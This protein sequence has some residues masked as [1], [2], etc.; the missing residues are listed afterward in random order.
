MSTFIQDIW[1][2]FLTLKS[3]S[4]NYYLN[5]G[6]DNSVI[7]MREENSMQDKVYSFFAKPNK[8]IEKDNIQLFLG[9]AYNSANYNVLLDLGINKIINITEE[10]PNHFE[11]KLDYLKISI[12]D[13]SHSKINTDSLDK[14]N[15]FVKEY[16]TVYVHCYQ[17]A[18]R[19]AAV[20]L[21][22]LMSK[23]NFG[24]EDGLD[25]LCQKHPITNINV[26][27][28]DNLKEYHKIKN[29]DVKND[30]NTDGM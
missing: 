21:H 17:G 22:L 13:D 16:D 9:S 30:I 23:F 4:Y 12:L 11:D 25:Y 18:S 10:I 7:R 1:A 28:I 15:Y 29:D 24:I 26:E 20:I 3:K 27:F 8:I 14:I 19:S 5:Y 2:F 6:K